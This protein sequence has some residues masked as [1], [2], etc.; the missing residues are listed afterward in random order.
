M[1]APDVRQHLLQ[2]ALQRPPLYERSADFIWTDD[3]VGRQMLPY[4]LDP[5]LDSASL[6]AATIKAQCRWIAAQTGPPGHRA[7][8]DIGCGPGLYC[9]RF[10]DHGFRVTGMDCNPHSLAY[11][12]QRAQNRRLP[13]DYVQANYIELAAGQQYDVITLINRDF[14]ALVPA[15]RDRVLVHV[16]RALKPDGCFVFDTLS[17]EAFAQRHDSATWHASAAPGFWAAGPHLVLEQS[18]RYPDAHTCLERQLVVEAAGPLKTFHNWLLFYTESEVADLLRANGFE[19]GASNPL[20]A[21]G[22]D[23]DP[24]PYLGFVA[25]K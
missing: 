20:L 9:E 14:G 11:A 23:E 1:N 17:L 15:E 19:I 4:H 21:D 6:K 22:I 10:H 5:N 25:V 8:L 3:H 24:A 13:I 12:R 16:H 18:L 7:L 2:A